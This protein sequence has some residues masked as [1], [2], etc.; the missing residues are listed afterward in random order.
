MEVSYSISCENTPVIFK[1]Y[2]YFARPIE[3]ILWLLIG[4]FVHILITL[5]HNSEE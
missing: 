2:E 4:G 1:L 3:M 5:Y